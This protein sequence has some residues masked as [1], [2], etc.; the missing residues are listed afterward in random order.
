MSK[1]R[2][3]SS[4]FPGLWFA[5]LVLYGMALGP[6]ETLAE[7]RGE[8]HVVETWRPDINVLGHNVLQYLFEYA[9]DTNELAP[10][11]GVSHQ[12]VNDTTLQIKLRQG[13]RFHN[14]E[15]FDAAA[16]KFNFEYQRKHNPGRG[17]Q[18][19][20]NRSGKRS[21]IRTDVPWDVMQPSTW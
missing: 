5:A 17:V 12:W 20:M 4:I 15:L 8:I 21:S 7:P 9:L 1:D 14:G 2:H 11:L 3:V 19:F 13:V 10:S 18:F 16:V 6:V